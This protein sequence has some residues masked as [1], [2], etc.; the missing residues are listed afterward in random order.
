MLIKKVTM[1]KK[2][3]KELNKICHYDTDSK[4]F[5]DSEDFEC[6]QDS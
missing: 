1:I 6:V 4:M 5:T 3:G 2:K